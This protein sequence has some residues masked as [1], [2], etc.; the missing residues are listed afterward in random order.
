VNEGF[1]YFGNE[2]FLFLLMKNFYIL[3]TLMILTRHKPRDITYKSTKY[4]N[5]SFTKDK[6]HSSTKYKNPSFTTI[7]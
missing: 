3:R 2:G 7:I 1:L 4:K 6:N 5:P